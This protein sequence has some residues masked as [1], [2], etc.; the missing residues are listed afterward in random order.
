MGVP[1]FYRYVHDRWPRCIS[2]CTERPEEAAEWGDLP[3]PNPVEFDALYLDFN[4]IVHNATHPRD[5]PAPPDLRS[6]M[7]EVFRLVDRVVV[8]A[9]PRKLLYIAVDG[10]APRAKM[11][12]QRS[13]RFLAAIERRGGTGGTDARCAVGP[14]G[15]SGEERSGDDAGAS[16]GDDVSDAGATGGGGGTRG[17]SEAS[18]SSF[19]HNAI[20]PGSTFMTE[21]AA[22]LQY[23]CSWRVGSSRAWRHL[24]VMLSDSTVP[25]EG[26]HSTR[27]NA[28]AQHVRDVARAR[29]R[30]SRLNWSSESSC[31]RGRAR[32]ALATCPGRIPSERTSSRVSRDSLPAST[33]S[34]A[35]R[36]QASTRSWTSSGSGGS[37]R[38]TIRTRPTASTGST[39]TW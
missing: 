1:T 36:T 28:P 11:D 14:R 25:G 37:S 5:R 8:A 10:V 34:L 33:A 38:D 20:T 24:C 27:R 13:R 32:V 31:T 18:G 21:L 15:G 19:D 17:E 12:Q 29:S 39:R 23:Y 9:R 26:E 7:Q 30:H 35:T 6:M 3:S 2:P 16:D 22:C 4:G